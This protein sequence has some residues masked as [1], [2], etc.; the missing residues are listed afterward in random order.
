MKAGRIAELFARMREPGRGLNTFIQAEVLKSVIGRSMEALIPVM[1]AAADRLDGIGGPI[2]LPGGA[3]QSLACPEGPHGGRWRKAFLAAD[4]KGTRFLT[5]LEIGGEP[6]PWIDG[7]LD[8]VFAAKGLSVPAQEEPSARSCERAAAYLVRNQAEAEALLVRDV[9]DHAPWS[10]D[11]LYACS[12]AIPPADPEEAWLPGSPDLDATGYALWSDYFSVLRSTIEHLGL[13]GVLEEEAAKVAER[14]WHASSQDDYA[15][16]ETLGAEATYEDGCLPG[17]NCTETLEAL[18]VL[19]AQAEIGAVRDD[20]T[21]LAAALRAAPGLMDDS[22]YSANDGRTEVMAF[23]DRADGFD[24]TLQDQNN[25]WSVRVVDGP[26][27]CVAVSAVRGRIG[28]TCMDFTFLG[29]ADGG[30]TM[31]GRFGRDLD[32]IR[33]WNGFVNIAST[34]ACCAADDAKDLT[35]APGPR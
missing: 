17:R 7:I 26:D 32:T 25:R 13:V 28:K 10:S 27:P 18:D 33:A 23:E 20:L 15:A 5:I 16:A 14:K 6:D 19:S 24:L 31:N 2:S 30:W 11:R 8:Q 22:R 1:E 4:P 35:D 29:R 9:L 34:L 3:V 12:T 21:G